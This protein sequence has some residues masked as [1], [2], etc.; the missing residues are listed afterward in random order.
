M[1][2]TF[3]AIVLAS[4]LF[5][6]VSFGDVM[7][8]RLPSMHIYCTVSHP[9]AEEKFFG[10]VVLLDVDVNMAMVHCQQWAEKKSEDAALCKLESCRP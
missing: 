8:S 10:V 9:K 5:G 3:F 1:K 2:K 4:S 6:A 7:T